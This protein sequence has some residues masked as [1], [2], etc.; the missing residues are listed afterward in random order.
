MPT[1][2]LRVVQRDWGNGRSLTGDQFHVNGHLLRLELNKVKIDCE[3][4]S[5]AQ[6]R[7]GKYEKGRLARVDKMHDFGFYSEPHREAGLPGRNNTSMIVGYRR[8]MSGR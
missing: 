6:L 7:F 3:L 1:G 2:H 5:A 4:H 8:G